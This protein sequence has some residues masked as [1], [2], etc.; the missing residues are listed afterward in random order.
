M[1]Y[2]HDAGF[3]DFA[4]KAGHGILKLLSKHAIHD[5]KV[6]DLGCGSGVWARMLVDA[7]YDIHGVDISADMI[8]ICRERVPEGHF[9]VGSLLE[10]SLP[11]CNAVTS[12]GECLNYLFDPQNNLDALRRLFGRI[13]QALTP[14]GLFVCDI[15]EPGY[16]AISGP[17]KRHMKADDWAV[18]VE[19]HED[20][21]SHTLTRAITT[22]RKTGTLY[23]RDEEVHRVQLYRG[24]DLE[25]AL[26]TAG[27]I[28]GRSRSY[29]D[30]QL[31]EAH[32]VLVAQKP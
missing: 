21:T 17:P 19:V 7:G 26:K 20:E 23:Q 1:A 14:G 3:T 27:F 22:F 13:Y 30:F 4:R 24:E 25:E 28:V 15:I 8:D 18:L 10:A 9:E 2:I 12:M 16:G 31:S 29:P 5:G 11:S 6:V 32:S